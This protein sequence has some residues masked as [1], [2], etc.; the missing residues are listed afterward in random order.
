MSNTVFKRYRDLAKKAEVTLG[1]KES[2]K[3]FANRIRKDKQ[4]KSL[5]RV[6][7]GYKARLIEPGGMYTYA[8]DP[9]TKEKLKFY[10][11]FPLIICLQ[12]V[13]GGWY[14]VNLHYLPPS[15]RAEV[16]WQIGYKKLGLARVAKAMSLDPRAVP[17]MKRYLFNHCQT[18]P[19]YIP[20]EEWEIAIQLPFENFQKAT[21][22]QVWRDSRSKM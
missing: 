13:K 18:T 11:S 22:K 12:I 4:I 15:L 21:L 3:W 20:K 2:A 14:G 5:D 7:D 9:K 6:T 8:Y 10:D 17:A 19:K 16:L 1:T